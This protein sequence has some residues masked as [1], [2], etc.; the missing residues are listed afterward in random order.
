MAKTVRMII[1]RKPGEKGPKTADVAVSEV[2]NWKSHGWVVE[3]EATQEYKINIGIPVVENAKPKATTV[4][5][6]K[7][8]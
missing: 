8:K 3:A 1:E 7:V 4:K 2:D 5:N 6:K